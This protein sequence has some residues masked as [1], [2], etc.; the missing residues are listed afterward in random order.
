MKVA[1][2]GLG[3]IGMGMAASLFREGHEVVGVDVREARLR[4][5]SETG[6][7]V[8]STVADACLDTEALVS[9]VVDARQ[10]ET[11]LF[12]DQGAAANLPSDA[13]C[14]SCA[15]L[16]PE[17]ARDFAQR[18]EDTGRHYLDAPTSGGPAKAQTGEIT[19]MGSGSSA[20]FEKAGPVLNAVAAKVYNLG[21]KAGVGSSM[22]LVN[23]HLAGVHIAV[24]CEAMAMAIRLG[25][26][27]RQVYDVITHAAGSSWMFENRVPHILE[28]DYSPQSAT[29][30]FT[31][32]LGIVLDTARS[33]Q[34]PVPM[35]STGLQLFEMAAAAG[36]GDDDDT[37]IIRVFAQLAGLQ[38]PERETGNEQD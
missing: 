11:V 34:F 6:G 19:I 25:L 33:N 16:P 18:M 12:G 9:V 13:V 35:A 23:Q 7:Q 29:S 2:I 3:S 14:I 24:A 4:K 32:D 17:N 22:K 10:T 21:A 5:F 31:K 37:S 1:V 30:I 20:A 28:G 38:L 36:M 8:A 26:E 27:P 15:T